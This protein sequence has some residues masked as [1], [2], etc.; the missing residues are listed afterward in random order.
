[1]QEEHESKFSSKESVEVN[2]IVLDSW[3]MQSIDDSAC[4]GEN[5]F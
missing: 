2:R 5:H 4:D 1:M 3:S